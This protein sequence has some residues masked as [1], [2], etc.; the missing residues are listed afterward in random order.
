MNKYEA[1]KAIKEGKTIT[2]PYFSINEW[3]KQTGDLFEFEDGTL[4]TP[5]E[6]WKWR[7]GKG[8]EKNWCVM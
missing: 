5:S 6:F 3:I 2:H 1:I 8:W 4:C 7:D